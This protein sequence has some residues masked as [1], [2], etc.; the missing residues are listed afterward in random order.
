MT[1][2]DSYRG[3]TISEGTI[4]EAD[5]VPKLLATLQEGDPET[6]AQVAEVWETDDLAGISDEDLSE[7]CEELMQALNDAAPE[8]TYFGSHEGDGERF[9]FWP[10]SEAG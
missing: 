4:R 1:L 5:L 9:G 2:P 10:I 8:G 3:Q 6:Y 7:L